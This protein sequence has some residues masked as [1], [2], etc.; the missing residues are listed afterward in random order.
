M[1]ELLGYLGMGLMLGLAGIGSCYGTSIAGNAAEGA[2]KKDSSKSA[3]YMILSALP[4]TQGLYGFLA[5]LLHFG[6][7][8]AETGYLW[9]GVG[10]GVGLVCLFSAIRQGQVCANGIVGMS[11]GYDVQTNTMIYAAF[12]EFYA[13]LALVA[14]FLV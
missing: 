10:I 3:G 9:F 14:T 5:F 2:L 7:V 8:N 11:Q 13:I 4:A 6:K 12:P 1:N